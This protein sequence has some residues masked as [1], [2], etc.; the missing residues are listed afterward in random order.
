[1]SLVSCSRAELEARRQKEEE[2]RRRM[3]EEWRKRRE[4]EE[5]DRQMALQLEDEAYAMK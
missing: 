1:M 2:E 5:A 4:Q 3:E